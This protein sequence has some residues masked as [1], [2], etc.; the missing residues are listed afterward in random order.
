VAGGADLSNRDLLAWFSDEER[1]PCSACGER[2]VVP[3]G[4]GS[5]VL[6][7]FACSAAWLDDGR[8]LDHPGQPLNADQPEAA[9]EVVAH[10]DTHRPLDETRKLL[11]A[12][13]ARG[14]ATRAELDE[15]LRARGGALAEQT[16]A[17]TIRTGLVRPHQPNNES[18]SEPPPSL[19]FPEEA[20]VLTRAGATL[21]GLADR[22]GLGH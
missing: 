12:V 18:D 2:A 4:S 5:R 19:A 13:A 17:Q 15:Q 1:W 11:E 20:Y 10:R 22:A 16:L 9:A 8:R 6:V 3:G 21:L 7:C 14:P